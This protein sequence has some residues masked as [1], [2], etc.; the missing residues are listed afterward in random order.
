MSE[1]VSQHYLLRA[2]QMQTLSFSAHIP[3][4]CF[5][6]SFPALVVFVEWLYLR[7]LARFIGSAFFVSAVPRGPAS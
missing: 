5:A 1:P 7:C 6:I 3:L 2:R 4:V